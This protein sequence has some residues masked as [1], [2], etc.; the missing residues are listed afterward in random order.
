MRIE[1]IKTDKG[2]IEYSIVGKGVP[3]L[4][5]HGGHSNCQ[6]TLLHKGFDTNKFQLITPSRPGYGNT[7]LVTIILTAKE[8]R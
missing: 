1:V 4:F 5:L 2:Q 7:P 8:N 6:E 3:I